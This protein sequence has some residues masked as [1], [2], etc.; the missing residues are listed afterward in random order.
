MRHFLALYLVVYLFIYLFLEVKNSEQCWFH[1]FLTLCPWSVQNTD[2]NHFICNPWSFSYRHVAKCPCFPSS[3]KHK[4]PFGFRR[5]N[6]W[7]SGRE[8]EW[9]RENGSVQASVQQL[10]QKTLYRNG[11]LPD[12]IISEA[13]LFLMWKLCFLIWGMVN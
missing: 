2:S 7:Y 12:Q 9:E 13:A 4:Q 11:W 1:L 10:N 6:G 3:M 8:M 5:R